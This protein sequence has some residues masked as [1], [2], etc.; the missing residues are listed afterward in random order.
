[1]A[2]LAIGDFAPWFTLPSTSNPTYHFDTVGGYRVVAFFFGSSKIAGVQEVLTEFFQQQAQFAA[3][4][5]PFFGV[6]IDPEDLHWKEAIDQ[7]T[8]FKLLWDFERQVSQLYG[9]CQ[10]ENQSAYYAPTAFVLNERLQ[11]IQIFPLETAT[12][13]VPQVMAYLEE[14]PEQTPPQMA[15][16]QAPVLLIPQ[17]FDRQFCQHLI[18]LY[19]A[20]GGED[21]GFMREVDGKTVAVLDGSFKKRRDLLIEDPD[22]LE[23]INTLI[24]RRIKPEI[25][26]AFQ[27]SITRFERYL[28]ACYESTNQGFFN[29]HRDN[30]TKGTAHRRFAMTL[31]L[32]T[33]EYE[34]GC[35]WFPEFG[36]QFYRPEVGEAIIF[37][38][39]LLHEVTPVTQG[40]RFALLS[41][42]YGD[43]DARVRER[44]R[45]Y[46]ADSK[47]NENREEDGEV[48]RPSQPIPSHDRP[49]SANLVLA[50]HP[51]QQQTATKRNSETDHA[52]GE[53]TKPQS[54]SDPTDLLADMSSEASTPPT[55]DDAVSS[56]ALT[57]SNEPVNEPVD[58]PVDESSGKSPNESSSEPLKATGKAGLGFQS[59]PP[60]SKVKRS[61]GKP[62]RV[63]F[64]HPNFPAQFRHLASTMATDPNYQVVFGTAR[65]EGN[66]QGVTKVLYS[67][68]REVSPETH[69]YV[70]TLEGAVLQGQ[71]VYR[72]V[73]QL[74]DDGFVPDIVYGHSG[75]GPTL[76]I[77]DALPKAKLLCYFEWFYNAH[78][79]DCDFDRSNPLTA[80]E[81]A[82]LRVRNAPILLDLYSCDHGLTPTQ[83]QHH[84][85]PHEF[86]S[87]LKILH[88][89]VNTSFFQPNPGAKLVL[90]SVNLDLSGV[91]EIITYVARGME[92]YRGFPQFMQAVSLLQKRRPNCHVV[93]VGE[94]RVAYGQELPDGKTYKQV[95]LEQLPLDLSRLHFAGY[96]SY[97]D[98]LK[99]LQ[100]SSVHVYLT[101]PFVLSWSM[102]EAMSAGCLILGSKTPP[103]M[104]LIRDGENG[105]L[106]DFF[107]SE[108]I[109]DRINDILDHPE[110]MAPLRAKARETILES[111]DLA[112]LL[113][114]HLEWLKSW[115]VK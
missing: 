12:N 58:E 101:Y 63:L 24:L 88:D 81:E 102:M 1:M 108:E 43:E 83:W 62:T 42:F 69:H 11:I 95:M 65:K 114:Q 111:Y 23:T 80:D 104:E 77:K 29:R 106:V 91:N 39:S 8:F 98:Y 46:L 84:Q 50:G 17:V 22:V 93:V 7:P 66:I 34:G 73:Q 57:P 13:Y 100:A 48:D 20:D 15:T 3:L 112:N 96:L 115:G 85:F 52:A 74:K 35:L 79:S 64:L 26:K 18:N 9:V 107:A 41:F 113:P 49:S 33:G 19:E 72:I 109:A 28:V 110:E 30:T 105:L 76:F 25:E 61:K 4:G 67:P 56:S 87:K 45:Q 99:V 82:K 5:I 54:V 38:C 21:S 2:R 6:G 31:N 71:A 97:N 75:W 10:V 44:N 14:L 51:E 27:F 60:K 92:P 47:E 89:G 16:R 53:R 103:V 59:K 36:R 90:P 40:R 94:D 86:R 68:S 32:N 78:G 37:S 55:S 70:R